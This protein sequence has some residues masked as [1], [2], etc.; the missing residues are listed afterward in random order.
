MIDIYTAAACVNLHY[1]VPA[2]PS[3]TYKGF[4]RLAVGFVF[5]YCVYGNLS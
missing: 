2:L 3:E 4:A 1:P 5:L